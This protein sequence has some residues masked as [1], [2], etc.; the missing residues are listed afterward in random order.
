MFSH[1]YEKPFHDVSIGTPWMSKLNHIQAV[2]DPS[3]SF[4]MHTHENALE[5]S[6]V[7]AGKGSIYCD[8][9][10][11][12]LEPGDIVIKNPGVSHAENSNP[13][14]PIEQICMLIEDVRVESEPANTLPVRDYS[15]VLPAGEKKEL[16]TA[17]FREI[18]ASTV[19]VPSPDLHYVNSLVRT[20]LT[21]ILEVLRHH[22]QARPAGDDSQMMHQVRAYIDDHYAENLSLTSIADHF[23]LSEYYLA[24]QFRKYTSFTVNNYIVSCRIGEAQRSL[25]HE[26]N[27]IDDIAV[28]CG[29]SNLSYF[30]TSFRKNV[31]CT[32]SAFK[33]SYSNDRLSL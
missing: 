26:D 18:L 8:G 15:P 24:R 5:I 33:K 11:Y 17:L 1:S 25:I 27:R 28:R 12:V 32:P 2:E 6:Y 29:Y 4:H 16:L 13:V 21:V 30:Y 10:L 9:R 19:S 31:G 7:F 22:L 3:W 14:D 20:S 23:H